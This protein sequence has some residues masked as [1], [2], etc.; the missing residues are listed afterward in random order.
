MRLDIRRTEKRLKVARKEFFRLARIVLERG[1]EL[2][3]R[4]QNKPSFSESTVHLQAEDSLPRAKK[5]RKKFDKDLVK[6]GVIANQAGMLGTHKIHRRT[7]R[8]H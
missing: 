2:V 5:S 4:Y 7:A 8:H 6:N 3:N 1:L